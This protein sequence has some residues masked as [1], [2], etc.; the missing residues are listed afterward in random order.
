MT[1][2]LVAGLAGAALTLG[3]VACADLE[4]WKDVRIIVSGPDEVQTGKT[5]TLTAETANGIVE[6]YRWRS[7]D[8]ASATVD[9]AGRVTGRRAGEV[10]ISAIGTVTERRGARA[11]TVVAPDAPGVP[12]AGSAPDAGR[13]DS[14]LDA[15]GAP[16][17]GGDAMLGDD[18][19]GAFDAGA[20]AGGPSFAAE[21]HAILLARCA[22]CHVAGGLAAATDYVLVDDP[23]IDHE[24][25]L[26]LVDT[27]DPDS[28][29]L[30]VKA[31]GDGNHGGGIALMSTSEEYATLRDWIAAGARP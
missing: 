13:T 1:W 16:D 3:A 5:I 20:D 23:T 11:I 22:A 12:D 31:R 30:L 25:V 24:T 14:G 17:S 7:D 28:S 10:T 4:E 6:R 21:T 9:R 8:E 15:A 27:A 26:A 2:R 18:D 19:A 29:P